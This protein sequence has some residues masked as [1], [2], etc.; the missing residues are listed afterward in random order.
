MDDPINQCNL[1]KEI[2]CSHIDGML[3]DFPK[4]S[5]L[6]GYMESKMIEETKMKVKV[7]DCT[8]SYWTADKVYEVIEYSDEAVLVIDDQ[9]AETPLY[10]GEYKV[11][12]Y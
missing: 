2:G 12:E 11:V 5:M 1:H 3:C 6:K 9:G 10:T 8:C 4:C 7:I